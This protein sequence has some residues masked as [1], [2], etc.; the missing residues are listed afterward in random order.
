MPSSFSWIPFCCS[1]SDPR[2]VFIVKSLVEGEG[3]KNVSNV[4]VP[5]LSHLSQ[6]S[7]VKCE[8]MSCETIPGLRAYSLLNAK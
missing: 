3:L 7:L 1:C 2:T 5:F 4:Q 8:R 6:E